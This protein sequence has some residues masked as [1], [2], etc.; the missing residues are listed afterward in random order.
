MHVVFS[1]ENTAYMRWQAE[2]LHYTYVRVGMRDQ[3]T[4]IVSRTDEP[5]RGFTCET[6][7]VRNRRQAIRAVDYAPLNKPGGVLEWAAS[8]G[9]GDE[10]VLLVDPDSAFVRPVADPGPLRPGTAFADTHAYLAPA[11]PDVALVLDRHCAREARARAQPVGVYLLARRD[12][13]AA[14]APRW[15]QK[16]MDI[17]SDRVCTT[18]LPDRGWIAEMLGY[19]IA[20]AEIGIVHAPADIA[21]VTGSGSLRRPVIHYCFPVNA[22]GRPWAPGQEER[23]LWSKW[24]YAP[25]D[26][27]PVERAAT[28]EARALLGVLAELAAIRRG[29]VEDARCD[30]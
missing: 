5:L 23:V 18:R 8:G 30:R 6:F 21:Q 2:L 11:H 26:R 1:C 9:R 7:P 19:V 15:L 28:E 27:P 10:T 14:L 22:S 24:S 29:G 12:D 20:A 4:A 16:A 13:L 25:W 3:L 17:R